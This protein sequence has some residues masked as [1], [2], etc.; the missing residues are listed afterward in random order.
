MMQ[1]RTA[2]SLWARRSVLGGIGVALLVPATVTGATLHRAIRIGQRSF[3]FAQV[4]VFSPQPFRGNPLAVVIGADALSDDEMAL[5]SRWTNL[6]ETTFLLRPTRPDADYRLRIFSHGDELPFAGHP[7]LGSCHV[8]LA[9]GGKPRGAH[10][11]QE[12]GVGL[13]RLRHASGRLAFEAPPLR[14]SVP[15]DPALLDR[16]RRGLGLSEGEVTAS[17]LLDGGLEVNALMITSRDRLLALKPDWAT[18]AVDGVGVIAPYG[19]KPAP[20][21]PD[22]EV[23][24]FDQTLTGGEDPVTG[25]FNAAIARWMIGAG[26]APAH[27]LVSQ[28][29]V[30]GRA[31]RVHVDQDPDGLWIGGDVTDHVKGTVKF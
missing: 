28:G 24:V 30:L 19:P 11:V 2:E 10:I 12:C 13:V 9:S 29:T 1:H 5:F 16:L 31:G 26:M 22:F 27:Y 4:D 6:S 15:V 14:K 20:G 23:R 3:A 7:T 18:L 25:S 21:Q 17:R 8:W